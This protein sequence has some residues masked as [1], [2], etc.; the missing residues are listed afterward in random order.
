MAITPK[1]L[2]KA[3]SNID[4]SKAPGR[5]GIPVVV[6]KNC[7]PELSFILTNLFNLHLKKSYFHDCWKVSSV[8]LVF[9]N[10]VKRPNPKNYY[11]VSL[12]SVVSKV[13]ENL[14]NDKLVTH[15]ESVGLFSDCQYGFVSSRS[16]ADLVTVVTG[17][18]A[19]F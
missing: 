14:I 13:F 7:E 8:A 15:L 12:L 4:S 1:I 5:N 18:N 17:R 10:V 16:T 3:K 11:P 6:L 9:K 2:K 19:S